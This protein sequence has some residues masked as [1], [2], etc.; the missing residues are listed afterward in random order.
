M[1]KI[2]HL[3]KLPKTSRREGITTDNQKTCGYQHLRE[4]DE[5][6]GVSHTPRVRRTSSLSSEGA[7]V[8]TAA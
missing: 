7:R 1:R 2:R 3:H 6:E 4:R 8:T 5:K